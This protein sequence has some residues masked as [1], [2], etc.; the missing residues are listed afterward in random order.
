MPAQPFRTEPA[1]RLRSRRASFLHG[2]S[3][4]SDDP[5]ARCLFHAQRLAARGGLA[6]AAAHDRV[7]ARDSDSCAAALDA[8]FFHDDVHLLRVDLTEAG[9][10]SILFGG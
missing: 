6:A 2:L 9:A 8:K 7:A 3:D 4:V 10:K 5:A 1:V